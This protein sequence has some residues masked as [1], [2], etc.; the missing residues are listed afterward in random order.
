MLTL[1]LG[2]ARAGKSGLAVRIA[3]SW[4]GPV[5]VIATAEA[6]DPEMADRIRRHREGRPQ[7]WEVVEEPV[8]LEHA[9]AALPDQAA[10][11]VD[12]L[13]LWVSN[14]IEKGCADEEIERRARTAAALAAGRR[15]PT[16][17]VS[18]EVGSGIVPRNALA[19][20][21][22]DVLGMVNE[23]WAEASHRSALVVAGRALP[24]SGPEV[25]T[26]DA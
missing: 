22:R 23:G 2:G 17:A 14:L 1:L 13:T 21:F 6:R 9:L 25:V 18:N 3:A 4:H 16:V 20:R 10:A 12:C 8:E 5:T 7:Q 15:S 11:I 19:R 26:G 24:L